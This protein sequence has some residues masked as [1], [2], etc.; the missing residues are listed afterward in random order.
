M[1]HYQ[2]TRT[3]DDYLSNA[4]RLEATEIDMMRNE[5]RGA[6]VITLRKGGARSEGGIAKI[7]GV[8]I[9]CTRPLRWT[10]VIFSFRPVQLQE[11]ESKGAMPNINVI[12]L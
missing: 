1:Q 9:D 12:T 8:Y 3:R 2:D 4:R 7:T 6:R 10:R 5:V 11:Q